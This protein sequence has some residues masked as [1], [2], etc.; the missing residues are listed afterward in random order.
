MKT[1]ED[2][3]QELTPTPDPDFVAEMEERMQMGFPPKRPP[4]LVRLTF[5][6][7]TFK[8]PAFAGA[9][10]SALLALLVT[11]SVVNDD[12]TTTTNHPPD[13][14][15]PL[16]TGESGGGAVAEQRQAQD[17]LT[18]LSTAAPTTAPIPPVDGDTRPGRRNRKV[19]QT[20][21]L[22]LAADTGEFDQV[23]DSIFAIADRRNGFVRN[24]SFTQ[25]DEGP[26]GGIFELLVPSNRL[27]STLNELSRVATVRSRS[28][29]GNDVTGRFVNAQDRLRIAHAE[30]KNLLL[31]L[32]S[33][34]T[35]QAAA[36]IRQR[37]EIVSGEINGLRSQ[38]RGLRERTSYATVTVELIDEDAGPAAGK[39][40]TD[41]AVDDAVGSLE[42][43][44]N[45]LIR[46]LGILVPVTLAGLVGWF[47]ASRARRRQRER[48][49]A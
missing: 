45:F 3:L 43:I 18:A 39:S 9:L 29:S 33:A 2:T 38:L 37:L 40:D 48:A 17:D 7:P 1:L 11:L 46:A 42:D 41:E 16:E 19:E 26:S 21:Q 4:R 30:R 32:E 25:S 12:G 6:L 49:L 14:I 34:P 22:T 8:H 15:Q 35:E 28:E 36:A 31:R 27:Q 13:S 44:L 23:A 5:E 24:S 47:A 10:A 20:A